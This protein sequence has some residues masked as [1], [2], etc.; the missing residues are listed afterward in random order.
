MKRIIGGTTYDTA[1][2]TEVFYQSH[3]HSEAWWGLYQ[4]R[5]GAFFKVVCQYDGETHEFS[6]L[7]DVEA[8]AILEKHANHLIEQ[9]FGPMP[10]YGSAEKRLTVRL[11]IGLARRVSDASAKHGINVNWYIMWCL[12]RCVGA[13]SKPS[14]TN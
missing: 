7:A 4:T 12:E 8:Q 14:V 11:P 2:A 3:D 6:P 1:T 13:E 9:Y 5:H 10:E